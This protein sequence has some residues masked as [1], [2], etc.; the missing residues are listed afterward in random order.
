M[1]IGRNDPCPCG[2]GK[3]YKYCCLSASPAVSD[4]LTELLSDQ[5]FDSIEELQAVTDTLVAKQ[6]HKP[7]DDFLGLSSE[8]VFRMLNFAFDTP[9][10]FQFSEQLLIEPSAPILM[11]IEGIISAIDETGLQATKA[12]GNLPQK[13]CRD[14]WSDYNKLYV[15]PD[16]SGVHKVNKEDDFF[17]LHVARI[18]LELAGFLRKTKGRFFVTKKYQKIDNNFGVKGIYPIIF[19][20]YCREFNWGYWDRYSDTPFIQQSFLF[21]LY[22]L[23]QHGEKMT[24]TSVYED[25]FLRAFPMVLD[26]MEEVSYFSSEE[27]FRHCYC[28]RV[29]QRFLV[30]LGLAELEVIKGDKD[31]TKKYKIKRTPLFDAVVHF[32]FLDPKNY[33][34][35]HSNIH[36]GNLH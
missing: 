2:S 25:D 32:N 10:L 23:K 34:T 13:L 22:L 5:E 7:H 36:K 6:N 9:E 20:T 31:Y 19:K 28:S 16:F 29:C 8:Q 27:S 15:D 3:K 24:F 12:N 18:T 1:K 33:K 21:A 14:V 4:E 35:M 30:F 17:E 11:L 26:E